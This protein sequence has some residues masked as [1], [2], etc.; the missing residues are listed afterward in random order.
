MLLCFLALNLVLAVA[1]LLPL[2]RQTHYLVRGCDFPRGQ[3]A[4]VLAGSLALQLGLGARDGALAWTALGLGGGALLVQAW[5][6]LPYS[7]L[8]RRE[9]PDARNGSRERSLRILTA[10]V[11]QTNRQAERFLALVREAA[12]DV[13]I[14]METDTWWRDQLD[15][16]RE[17]GFAHTLQRPLDNLYGMLLYSRYPLHG[18]SIETL[19]EDDVPSMHALVELP[20]GP[21]VRLHVLHPAPPSPT[22][23]ETS[24]ERDAELIVVGR[25]LKDTQQPTVVAGDL[26]DVAWSSTTRLFRKISGLLD[27]RVGR[28][29]FCSFNA[30]VPFLRWPLDHL[31]HSAHFCLNDIRR[32]PDFGS[33]HFP[34]LIDLHLEP[35][36]AGEGLAVDED[37]RAWAAEK[38]AEENVSAADVPDPAE[39]A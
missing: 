32:L 13:L 38:V 20:A 25:E 6:I 9:V 18:A 34:L 31:F 39:K 23:N 1:T 35:A 15:V 5:W 7:R 29:M 3:I 10:N 30:R 36:D 26:N 2:S 16:L 22:E 12:P 24:D 33:D 19:V 37:D 4:A 8:G 11:L 14:A 27:P 21:R 28:G 17:E